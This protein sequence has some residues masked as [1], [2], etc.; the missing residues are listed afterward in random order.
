MSHYT[1]EVR[2]ICESLAGF[3]ESK[4]YANVEEIISKSRTGVFDFNYPIFDD[5]YKETLESKILKH[6]YTREIGHETVGRWK[7]ALS[8]KMNEIMPYYNQLYNSALIEFNPLN[9]V[10]IR[11]TREEQGT[12]ENQTDST[13]TS[14]GS[15]TDTV[16]SNSVTN[17]S[18]H[19]NF[20]DTPQNTMDTIDDSHIPLT[21]VTRTGEHNTGEVTT[22]TTGTTTNNTT[23]NV[24][25]TG[26]DTRNMIELV[27]GKRGSITYSKML[28][29]FRKTFVNIDVMIIN[30]LNELFLNLW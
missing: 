12:N 21:T 25:S 15:S 5:S 18:G 27:T 17:G 3:D 13:G 30:E 22:T 26:S 9:D 14:N 11:T 23:G 1:T 16:H 8:Q 4:G 10:N 7:L 29:E 19:E 24:N 20:S 2:H 6:F 28:E